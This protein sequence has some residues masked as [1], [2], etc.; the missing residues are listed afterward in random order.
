MS[1]RL[2]S[3]FR[4]LVDDEGGVP[5]RVWRL[6]GAA[7]GIASA[8]GVRWLMER[9]RQRVSRRG[10]APLNPADERMGWLPSIAW[11]GFIAVGGAFG[12]LVTERLLAAA[13][14]RRTHRPVKAMPSVAQP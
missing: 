3:P 10:D 12:R 8:A 14:Q 4:T 7:V 5:D 6:G 11:A 2:D 1:T 9:G 13:W